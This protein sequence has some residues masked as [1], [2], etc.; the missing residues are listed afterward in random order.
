MAYEN[1]Q[2]T[3][4]T[5]L[6]DK[7]NTFAVANGWT[8]DEPG[9]AIVDRL[10]LTKGDIHVAFRWSTTSPTNVGIYQHTA[11]SSGD[12]GTHT[13]DS[14]NGNV[15]GT[16]ADLDNERHVELVDSTMQY[17][18]FE[19]DN[20]IHIVCEVLAGLVY[21]HFGFGELIK[22]GTWTGGAYAYGQLHSATGSSKA[23]RTGSTALLDGLTSS[24][25]DQVA[26]VRI[27]GAPEQT[28]GSIWGVVQNTVPT[29]ND[30]GGNARMWLFGGFRAGPTAT[31]FGRFFA[32]PLQGLLPMYPLNIFYRSPTTTNCWPLGQVPAIRGVNIRHHA[33]GDEITVGADTW[34]VFPTSR[35]GDDATNGTNNQGI[36]YQKVTT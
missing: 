28:A 23:L 31:P 14:G 15:T 26:T 9:G 8:K 11:Y 17:W 13:G 16:N 30:T 12:P 20:Y 1:A 4:I 18:F 3:D 29:L 35:K 21:R 36:A 24:E 34:T 6:F 2:A 33:A 19:D 32:T 7:L 22:T 27:S 25:E 5:D 10:F